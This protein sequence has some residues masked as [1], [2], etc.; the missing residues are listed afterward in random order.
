MKGK[1]SRWGNSLALRIP[2]KLASSHHLDEGTSVE[3]I[4]DQGEL[5]LRPVPE[6]IYHL[7]E[8]LGGITEQNLH[9]EVQ[10]GSARG[11]EVW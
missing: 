4:E 6:Q 5:K 9:E 8:L 7:D 1:I 11:K 10:T 3:I 2:R